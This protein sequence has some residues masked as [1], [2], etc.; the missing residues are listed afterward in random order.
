MFSLPFALSVLVL[1]ELV[2]AAET[3]HIPLQRRATQ[4]HDLEYYS[5][6]A[7][8]LRAK[9]NIGAAAAA[10]TGRRR[11][12]VENIPVIN[13]VSSPVAPSTVSQCLIVG[14]NGDVSYL[15]TLSIGTP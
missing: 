3:F 14:Q 10:S 11:A 8:S 6:A 1:S 5:A 9:Y 15:G 4:P 7:D 12:A 2:S 13:Q